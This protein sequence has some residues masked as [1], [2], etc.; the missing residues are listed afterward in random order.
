MAIDDQPTE[1]KGMQVARLPMTHSRC[2]GK[3]DLFIVLNLGQVTYE[4]FC[5]GCEYTERWADSETA[6][7]K[8]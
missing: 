1:A 8:P 7:E 6:K 3:A 5:H 2:G 4:L